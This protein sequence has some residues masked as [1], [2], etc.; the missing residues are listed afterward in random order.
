MCT[1]EMEIPH[2]E[3]GNSMLRKWKISQM[4]EKS[5]F[6]D[7]P[8]QKGQFRTATLKWKFRA[9]FRDHHDHGIRESRRD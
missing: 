6:R 7:F 2:P 8:R 5:A 3:N 9:K 1:Q 4:H